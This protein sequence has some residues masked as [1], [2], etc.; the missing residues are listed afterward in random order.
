ML[1][2][3][4]TWAPKWNFS[5]LTKMIL[6]LVPTNPESFI[7]IGGYVCKSVSSIL[8]MLE[9]WR[10]TVLRHALPQTGAAV[11]RSCQQKKVDIFLNLFDRGDSEVY[12]KMVHSTHKSIFVPNGAMECKKVGLMG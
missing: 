4:R 8:G 7:K 9:Y 11:N 5:L 2:P 10:K 1:D 12:R 3:V 6:V